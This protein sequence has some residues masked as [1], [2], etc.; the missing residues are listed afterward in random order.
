METLLCVVFV[1]SCVEATPFWG[2]EN[3]IQADEGL[4]A[5]LME[6]GT[7]IFGEPNAQSGLKSFVLPCFGK[8]NVSTINIFTYKDEGNLPL[9]N[10]LNSRVPAFCVAGGFGSYI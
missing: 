10:I 2:E 4:A 1:L 9:L 7:T 8:V 3:V 5:E 6:L